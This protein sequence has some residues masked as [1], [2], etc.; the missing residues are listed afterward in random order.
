LVL[1]F[2]LWANIH[3]QF[4]L[5]WAFLGLFCLF[6]GRCPRWHAIVLTTGCVLAVL[7]NPYHIRLLGVIWE[8]ATQAQALRLVRELQPP[9]WTNPMTWLVLLCMVLSLAHQL[10]AKPRDWFPVFL[11]LLG[12][13]F[14]LRMQ[15][16]LWVGVLCASFHRS[17][18]VQVFF[19]EDRSLTPR[20]GIVRGIIRR[21]GTVLVFW[22]IV[23]YFV[24]VHTPP[25]QRKHFEFSDDGYPWDCVKFL[26][27]TNPPGPIF[28]TFD[29]GGY[30]IYT[31]PQYPVSIDGRTN[32]YGNDRLLRNYKTMLAEPGWRDDPDLQVARVAFLPK[33]IPLTEVLFQDAGWTLAFQDTY[34]AVF[35]RK[36]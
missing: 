15:R 32:L 18:S 33:A 36:P 8:Y 22:L 24:S 20:T 34:G 29:W 21:P 5:G 1:I 26:R 14:A 10:Q 12:A 4:V 16:D 28:N 27:K 7:V 6:P 11:T 17:F 31:L 9:E 23:L 2:I 35:V 19:V 25:N 13:F 3:I 30:L